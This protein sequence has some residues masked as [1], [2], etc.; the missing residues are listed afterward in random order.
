M[1]PWCSFL[2]SYWKGPPVSLHLILLYF[3][4]CLMHRVLFSFKEKELSSQNMG[5][6]MHRRSSSESIPPL[7]FC[8]LFLCTSFVF[9][10]LLH[11]MR[12]LPLVL[13]LSCVSQDLAAFLR[14]YQISVLKLSLHVDRKAFAGTPCSWLSCFLALISQL[15]DWTTMSAPHCF[16]AAH[17]FLHSM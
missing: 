6:S 9:S 3:L 7:T 10:A 16:P 5:S 2:N 1:F 15:T 8:A 12:L 13:L 14:C 4:P 17:M 11:P